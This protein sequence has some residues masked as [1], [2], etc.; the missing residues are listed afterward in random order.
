MRR[1]KT[2][3]KTSYKKRRRSMGAVSSS[4]KNT[5]METLYGVGGAIAAKYV[6]TFVK[7]QAD[8]IDA[9]AKY[10]D[11]IGAATPIL[12]GAF[13]PSLI[14]QKSVAV[15][16][17]GKGM[18]IAGGLQLATAAGI[19]GFPGYYVPTV[20][21]LSMSQDYRSDYVPAVGAVD[22]NMDMAGCGYGY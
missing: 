2:H 16:S 14:K 18:A 4:V 8:K 6:S 20:G 22:M 15:S 13:L 17:I 12:V 21:A 11:Y 3:K 7:D 5:L 10:S 1:K 9:V 19:A